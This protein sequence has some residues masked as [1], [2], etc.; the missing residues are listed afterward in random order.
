MNELID[1]IMGV[2]TKDEKIKMLVNKLKDINYAFYV[3]GTSK[4]LK[5]VMAD[6]KELIRQCEFE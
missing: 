6:T 2:K 1:G 5:A 3:N 4:A